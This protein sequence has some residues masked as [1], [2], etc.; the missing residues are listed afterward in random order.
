MSSIPADRAHQCRDVP[1]GSLSSERRH[2]ICGRGRQ[3]LGDAP[4]QRHPVLVGAPVSAPLDPYEP[5]FNQMSDCP[6][7]ANVIDIESVRHAVVG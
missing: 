1:H 4:R 6:S 7:D 3:R 2:I 5:E